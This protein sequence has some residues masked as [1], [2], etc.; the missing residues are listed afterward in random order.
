V[1][2]AAAL[3]LR[4]VDDDNPTGSLIILRDRLEVISRSRSNPC[5]HYNTRIQSQ[6]R[7]L[8]T[9]QQKLTEPD[10]T[11]KMLKLLIQ[12]VLIGTEWQS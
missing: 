12:E 1:F 7:T 9:L 2:V 3:I 10:T 4:E 11:T 8:R 5:R 6:N